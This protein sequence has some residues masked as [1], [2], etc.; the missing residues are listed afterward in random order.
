LQ[1]TRKTFSF[2]PEELKIIKQKMLNWSR[3]F[4]IFLFLDSNEYTAQGGRYECLLGAGALSVINP[5]SN[6]PFSELY[7]FYEG[8]KDWVF[9]HI[10]YDLKNVLE[11]KLT[12]SHKQKHN[13]P[14][15]QFFV[16]EILVGIETGT[17]ELFIE[18]PPDT[19]AGT[20][21]QQ[22][23]KTIVL[24]AALPKLSFTPRIAHDAYL[25]KIALLREHIRN[26]D[27]YEINL[28][29]ERYCIDVDL[30]PLDAFQQLNAASPAPF[31]A[32]YRLHDQYL[33][34]ASPER[35][36]R[37]TGNRII[38]QPIKGTA[39]RSAD[40][41]EDALLKAAL[42]NSE[43]ERAENVM[44]TDLVRSDLAHSCIPGSI[45]VDELFGIYTFL[46]VHQMISAISGTLAADSTLADVL[47]HS[48][49]MGSM[50]G[51]PK[52]KVMDLIERHEAARRE[53]FAGTVGYITPEGDADF[54]VVI[55]SLFYNA[56]S[57]YLSY[58]TGGAITW[59]SDAES[60]W[61]EL[62]L[63]AQAMERLFQ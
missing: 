25:E 9:G 33:L 13:F 46:Q 30:D 21:H 56:A 50:T 28:C 32:C 4:S 18:T 59:D 12:S 7:H 49:P 11:P 19:D 29:S 45:R 31:A 14:L 34:C 47:H 61:Q 10:A 15:L 62:R 17:S 3:K 6:V 8:K 44:I 43:K 1:R 54:N 57:R 52:V 58:Q 37:K 48:F 23:I 38:S 22:I 35:Y 41:E 26:G 42:Y 40:P 51:A 5:E 16:P 39:R 55:R 24:A 36:L 63:K 60:E 53:L 20:I 27:C 2:G